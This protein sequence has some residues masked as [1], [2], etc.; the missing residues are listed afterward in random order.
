M[1]PSN[2]SMNIYPDNKISCFKVNLPGT[3]QVD[4]KQGEVVLKE[5]QFAHLWCNIR[6]D[7]NYFI[8]WYNTV[9][10]HSSNERVEF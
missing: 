3:L 1:L 5:I 9:I 7:K 4:Q 2:I 10:G 8:G 6:N